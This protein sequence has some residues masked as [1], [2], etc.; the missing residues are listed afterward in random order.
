MER[1]PE[2]ERESA[3]EQ[4]LFGVL[5]PV[6]AEDRRGPI[7]LKGPRHRAVLA[8]LIVAR[9]RV[10]PV[11]RLVSDLWPDSPPSGAVGS[12]QTFV[13][14]LRR[15]LEPDR[16]PRTP[17]RLLVTDGPGYALRAGPD[18]VDAWRFETAV[19]EAAKL[20]P[21]RALRR[22]DEALELWRGPAYADFAREEWVRGERARLAELRL[23]SVERGAEARLA[24]GLAAEAVPDLDAHLA[25][26]PWREDAWR[27]LALALYRAG[28]QGDALA[29]LRRARSTLVEQLGLDPGP[30]L[31]RLEAD[32]L[33]QD[34]ALN[35]VP[36]PASWEPLARPADPGSPAGPASPADPAGPGETAARLWTRAAAAYD[37]TVA[38]GARARL[39]TTVGLLRDLA[40]TGGGG[41]TAAREHRLAAVTAAEEFGDPELTGRVIGAFDVPAI[42]T[43]GDDPELARRIVAAAE[44][45]LAALPP[46][47]EHGTYDAVRC[48]LLA[49]VAVETRGSHSSRGPQA[50]AQAE[51]IARRLDDPALL[52]FALNGTFMQSFT[53]AGLAP[54]RA[55]TGAELVALGAR[56][57]LVTFEVLGH[58]ILLQARCALGDFAAADAHAIAADRLAALH[59]LPLVGVFTRWYGA[60]RLSAS[61]DIAEARSAY[62][63][64]A[65]DLPDSGM[66]G[67]T[68]GLLPLALLSLRFSADGPRIPPPDALDPRADWGPYR[69][70][71]TPL[72]A[73]ATGDHATARTALRELPEPPRDLL[74]EACCCLEATAALALGDRTV[75]T[76]V[77]DR[78]APAS[79]ELAG[80]GSGLL[81]LGPVSD[82]LA[83]IDAALRR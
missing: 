12:V 49:T 20:P 78:L 39:E 65:T 10:V 81:T 69:P 32:I 34:A 67:L 15:A 50:A 72:A 29:V 26:H 28:R 56:H 30:G 23:R 55:E 42:W 22:L 64:A 62:E 44:R 25:D 2:P 46:P 79:A 8:R 48:R 24:L 9:R 57:S 68:H 59:E 3:R 36:D 5:G 43:R 74:Y 38:A 41:L 11:A 35:A 40:V 16:P 13:A 70:W 83:A 60:L 33:A 4:V 14:A 17:A 37:R 66:P 45:T 73:L 51:S 82:Y 58:L 7:A 19:G 75:L 18:A 53:R 71:I 21:A 80:A 54:R 63:S 77:R 1:E 76:R 47:D 52:A 6:T 61:G 27:L 31:R